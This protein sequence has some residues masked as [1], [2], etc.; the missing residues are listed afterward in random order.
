[1]SGG[2]MSEEWE[3]EEYWK[4]ILDQYSQLPSRI[5]ISGTVSQYEQND[6]S[7]SGSK[8]F[9]ALILPGKKSYSGLAKQMET[10]V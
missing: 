4:D 10:H 9:I 8:N 3:E 5:R 6:C 2:F 1:M 7:E